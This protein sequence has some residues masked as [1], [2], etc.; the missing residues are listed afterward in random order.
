[1]N[2]KAE[3]RY[4]ARKCTSTIPVPKV[5]NGSTMSFVDHHKKEREHRIH[6]YVPHPTMKG[7][8]FCKD[9]GSPKRN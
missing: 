2:R 8:K 3:K 5:D 1:M 7:V 9:C 6:N 4:F